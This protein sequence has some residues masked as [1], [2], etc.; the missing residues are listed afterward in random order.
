MKQSAAPTGCLRYRNLLPQNELSSLHRHCLPFHVGRLFRLPGNFP[1]SFAP[2]HAT[3]V[4]YECDFR[5][6]ARGSLV[7]AG[8]QHSTLST[9]LG[10][11]AVTCATTN[12]VGGFII[13]DR[14]L[15]MFKK[16]RTTA[17]EEEKS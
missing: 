13:T 8:A 5:Y 4:R 12:V 17:P 16:K 11:I 1:R 6:F 2:A 14:M 3:D 7:A 10:F 9:T 15:R